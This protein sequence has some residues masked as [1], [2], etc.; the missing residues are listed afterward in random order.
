M[1]VFIVLHS[2]LNQFFIETHLGFHF[3]DELQVDTQLL[4]VIAKIVIFGL[5]ELKKWMSAQ[6][7]DID[8]RLGIRYK[9]FCDDIFCFR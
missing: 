9:N 3:L 1:I 4:G 8:S 5:V 2:L 7:V 6:T